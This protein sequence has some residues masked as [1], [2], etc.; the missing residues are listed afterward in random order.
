MLDVAASLISPMITNYLNFGVTP[1]LMGNGS[2]AGSSVSSVYETGSG[3]IQVA[4][5]TQAQFAAQVRAMGIEHLLEDPR[6]ANR[7]ARIDNAADLREALLAAFA[8]ADAR[9]WEKRL[10]A[11]GV[12]AGAVLTIP[13]LAED[14]QV[15]ARGFI[16]RGPLPKG[17]EGEFQTVGAPFVVADERSQPLQPTPLLG[18]QTDE[19]LGEIGYSKAEIQALRDARAVS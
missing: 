5:A 15:G 1:Q 3:F 7:E 12:P 19:V 8:T 4:A 17:F 6:F 14:E 10:A 16:R 9:T 2:P 18:G 13:E 11:A